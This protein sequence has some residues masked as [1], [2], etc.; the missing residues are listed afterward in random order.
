M[1]SNPVI[2]DFNKESNLSNWV[3]V[4]D[5][6]MGVRLNMNNFPAQQMEEIAFLIG[7][8][9]AESFRLE[10]D[11]IELKMIKKS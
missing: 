2:F 8:K 1:L 6:I 3:I 5:V 10:I 11:K 7:N 9:K 4:D